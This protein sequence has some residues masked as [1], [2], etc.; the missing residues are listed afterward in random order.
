MSSMLDQAI[1]D[2]KALKEAAIKECRIQYY[3]K[4]LSGNQRGS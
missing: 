4:I 3:R 2:A 1:V